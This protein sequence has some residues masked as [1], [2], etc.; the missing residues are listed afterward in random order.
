MF[1]T[2]S[3]YSHF[4]SASGG[5]APYL[6]TTTGQ[7]PDGLTVSTDGQLSGTPSAVGTFNFDVHATD[8]NGCSA[9]G[10][11][12]ATIAQA[13]LSVVADNATREYGEA[14]PVFTGTITGAIAG[15]GLSASF[16]SAA[17]P[18]SVP[19]A[20]P[21]VATINDPN[22]RLENYDVTITNGT[23]TVTDATAPG[24]MLGLGEN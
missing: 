6:F 15:D 12:N 19:G 1:I 11:F 16:A 9:T 4:F 23:L 20:Y 10:T 17:T 18:T 7:V 21:I 24:L 5:L 13:P 22:G 2:G 8:A 14:N 3:P